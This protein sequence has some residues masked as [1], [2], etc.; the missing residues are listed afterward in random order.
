MKRMEREIE[1]ERKAGAKEIDE[2]LKKQR[3][4]QLAEMEKKLEQI[5]SK[6]ETFN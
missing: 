2:E 1:K 6:K 5:K 3:N 4:L